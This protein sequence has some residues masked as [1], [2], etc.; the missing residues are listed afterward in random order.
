MQEIV[1]YHNDLNKIKLPKFTEIEQDLLM[2]ILV[3]V[4]NGNNKIELYP[5]DF[6][7]TKKN[8]TDKELGHILYTLRNKLFKADFMILVEDKK[9]GLI[10]E[11]YVNLFKKFV[12]W[13]D[14]YSS[15]DA[16]ILS[17]TLEINPEFAYLV[18][19]LTA[20]FTR[21]ELA[22]FIALSGKYTKTL[23]RL[24]KQYRQ[25]G[26][27]R[28]EWEEF[29]RILDIPECYRQIDIDQQILK[30]AIK[31]LTAERNLFD[32]KRIPFKDLTY[33]KIKGK[34]RG[35]GGNVIAIE[36]SFKK[37]ADFLTKDEQIEFLRAEN[38]EL[39][40]EAFNN[41]M[42]QAE[43]Q[44][45]K[46]RIEKLE[47]ISYG[48]GLSAYCGL[49][50]YSDKGEVLRV[51][52]FMDIPNSSDQNK[53]KAEI[54]NEKTKETFFVYVESPKHLLNIIS[55]NERDLILNN[56]EIINRRIKK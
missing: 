48:I 15:L 33:T 46:E 13:Y 51:L 40:K 11:E 8:Y 44:E 49:K 34:G 54:L 22:E 31:E 17:V 37:Q 29:K 14:T 53:Y 6:K 24:L 56:Q 38:T 2:G 1:K 41:N 3:Q 10:G 18:E 21:F 28:M 50:Y 43:N 26:Y 16:N 47:K 39:A 42:A 52:D 30:P 45:L 20:N 5:Q 7:F 27:M 23:Y 55:K 36:F 19:Q 25:T 9:R 32:T 4:K 35:R 12:L